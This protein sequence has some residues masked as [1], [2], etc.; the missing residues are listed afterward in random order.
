MILYFIIGLQFCALAFFILACVGLQRQNLFFRKI[1]IIQDL[2]I[3]SNRINFPI[4]KQ[5]DNVV[6]FRRF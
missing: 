6:P 3:K 1:I 5:T 2:L 4:K